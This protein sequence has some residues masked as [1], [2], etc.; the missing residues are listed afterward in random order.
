[1]TKHSPFRYFKPGPGFL[2]HL[3]QARG[4]G[5]KSHGTIGNRAGIYI[6]HLP[7]TALNLHWIVLLGPRSVDHGQGLLGPI[8][9]VEPQD[10]GPGTPIEGHRASVHGPLVLAL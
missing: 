8:V 10:H 6:M 7:C 5:T 1:M 9:T 3:A 2:N 4:P